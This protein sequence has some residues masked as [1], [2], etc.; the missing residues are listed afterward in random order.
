[1]DEG[2]CPSSKK[3][4]APLLLGRPIRGFFCGLTPRLF[5]RSDAT[6]RRI[7]V[8]GEPNKLLAEKR[9]NGLLSLV[10]SLLYYFS[11]LLPSFWRRLAHCWLSSRLF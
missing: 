1:M 10:L 3:K 2:S 5:H 4:N 11:P 8:R 6:G 7:L 9:I